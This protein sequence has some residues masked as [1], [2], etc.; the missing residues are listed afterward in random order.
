MK[1]RQ[2]TIKQSGAFTLIEVLIAAAI[3]SI[4]LLAIN[5]VFFSALKL[6]NTATEAV[7]KS[8]P[9]LHAVE[10][11]QRDLANVTIPGGTISGEFQTGV[12]NGSMT[13]QG[14]TF[15]TSSGLIDDYA[16]FGEIQRVSYALVDSTNGADGRDLVRYVS[17][18]VLATLQEAPVAQRLA[19]GF[20]E[21]AFFYFDGRQWRDSWD[22]ASETTKLPQAVKVQL[23]LWH[24]TEAR[25]PAPMELVVPILVQPGTNQTSTT[26]TGGATS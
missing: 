1:L 8:G 17:R 2:T 14:P 10:I 7:A 26:S 5:A 21:I 15:C 25:R 24:E 3:F 6:R 18:N 23:A 16:P 4:V 20:R 19:G 11:L 9:M 13:V 22:S 12:N